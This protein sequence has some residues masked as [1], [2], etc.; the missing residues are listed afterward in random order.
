[1]RGRGSREL[2]RERERG[3]KEKED[4]EYNEVNMTI[5]R[6]FKKDGSES[7]I[8]LPLFLVGENEKE[9]KGKRERGR[10]YRKKWREREQEKSNLLRCRKKQ[11][12]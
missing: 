8:I 10:E 9:R 3:K 4:C 2:L 6:Q 7:I 1:M 12:K 11:E 5:E